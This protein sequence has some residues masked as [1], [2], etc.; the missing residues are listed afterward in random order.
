[1]GCC[2]FSFRSPGSNGW[3]VVTRGPTTAGSSKGAG[4]FEFLP[5]FAHAA[6][7]APATRNSLGI[8]SRDRS[9]SRRDYFPLPLLNHALFLS[10]AFREISQGIIILRTAARQ[11]TAR[12]RC[13][14]IST[15][16][17]RFFP[18]VFLLA[19]ILRDVSREELFFHQQS[20]TILFHDDIRTPIIAFPVQR[21]NT[22]LRAI[23]ICRDLQL[24]YIIIA[25]TKFNCK[26]AGI[27]TRKMRR[28]G[29][30]SF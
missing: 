15:V 10:P 22:R 20:Q 29:E 13:K 17:D 16:K 18:R 7:S 6:D 21:K 11:L 30:K 23:C 24:F 2:R 12:A 4:G 26:F 14:I 5:H 27:F 19:P 8:A 25:F 3:L 1:V 28:G 9:G